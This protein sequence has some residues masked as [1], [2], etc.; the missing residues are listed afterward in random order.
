MSYISPP[1]L[2]TVAYSANIFRSARA[3]APASVPPSSCIDCS[4]EDKDI[5]IPAMLFA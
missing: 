2:Y 5:I 1:V 4:K 3:C